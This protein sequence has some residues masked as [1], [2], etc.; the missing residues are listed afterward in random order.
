MPSSQEEGDLIEESGKWIEGSACAYG[1]TLD[2]GEQQLTH[3]TTGGPPIGGGGGICIFGRRKM[4]KLG[5]TLCPQR[6]R[7][8]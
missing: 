7:A 4:W 5:N 3:P 2:G 6:R 8:Q 1:R